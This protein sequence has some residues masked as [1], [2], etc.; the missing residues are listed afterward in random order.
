MNEKPLY[1]QISN[2]INP[3]NS[4]T[5]LYLST[6]NAMLHSAVQYFQCNTFSI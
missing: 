6:F 2:Q 1:S 4:T 5:I 3:F